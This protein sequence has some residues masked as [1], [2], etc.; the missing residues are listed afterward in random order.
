MSSPSSTTASQAEATKAH[1]PIGFRD[2]CSALLIPLNMCRRENKFVP[3]QC[4]HERHEYEKCQYDDLMAR[5]KELAKQKPD[6]IAPSTH[7]H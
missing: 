2:H 1:L 6:A 4:D 3:W 5:M 7:S